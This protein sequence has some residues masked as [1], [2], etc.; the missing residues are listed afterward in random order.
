L[1]GEPEPTFTVHQNCGAATFLIAEDDGSDYEPITRY[2]NV[3]KFVQDLSK[4]AVALQSGK[5]T[6]GKLRAT[7]A[8]RH[9]SLGMLTSLGKD[10]LSNGTYGSLGKFMRKIVMVGD[11]HF[12][13]PYNF[14]LERVERCAIHY[15]TPDGRLIPFCTMNILYRPK[16]EQAFSISYT[17]KE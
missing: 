12:M 17:K 15:A 4:A 2:A 9:V 7:S 5:R 14:D 11:M 13:D 6:Q 1:K 16:I 3:E 8:L 10:F